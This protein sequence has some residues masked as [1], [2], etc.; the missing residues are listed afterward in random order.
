MTPIAVIPGQRF[1]HLTATRQLKSDAGGNRR[2]T[3]T[4]DCGRTCR[5][6]VSNVTYNLRRL[7]WASCIACYRAAGGWAAIEA[8]RAS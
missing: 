4:C 5:T 2:W 1:G 8:R 3:F 6:R 7:G